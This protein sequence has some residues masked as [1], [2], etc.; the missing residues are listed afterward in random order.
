MR[1]KNLYTIVGIIACLVIGFLLGTLVNY[2]KVNNNEL[3]GTIGKASN[4]RNVTVAEDDIQLRSDLQSDTSLQKAY[5]DFYTFHYATAAELTDALDLSIKASESVND[6]KSSNAAIINGLKKYRASINR[7]R[8]DLLMAISTLMNIDKL[9]AATI[10]EVLNNAGIALSQL[11]YNDDAVIAF[12][13]ESAYYLGDK[14]G[15]DAILLR[16]AHDKLMILQI[17]KAVVMNDKPKMKYLDG[18]ELFAG[19]EQ[20]N[21]WSIENLNGI[22]ISDQENLQ[23]VFNSEKLGLVNNQNALNL[24]L[25]FNAENF[26]SVS[27]FITA[28]YS[29]MEQLQIFFSSEKLNTGYTNVE[30]LNIYLNSEMVGLFI[31]N[32]EQMESIRY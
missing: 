30:S 13:D 16:K 12:I 15:R 29:N 21:I 3:A 31:L 2:P 19:S 1:K 5:I 22:I 6:F 26:N 14:N 17:T 25:L 32:V 28:G 18:K 24:A 8:S 7:L 27:E 9:D 11:S 23:M 20:L 4:Y 10:S